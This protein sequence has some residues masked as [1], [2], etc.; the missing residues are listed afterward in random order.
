MRIKIKLTVI[1]TLAVFALCLVVPKGTT[2]TQVV[3][4]GQRFK[5]IKVVNDMPADQLGRVMNMFSAS[6][7]VNCNFCHI[8]N[9]KD[10]DKDDKK[11]KTTAREMIKMTLEINKGHFDSRTEVSCNTCHGGHERPMSAPNLNRV[12]AAE[13]PKQP[14]IK[15]TVDQI[16]DKYTTALGGKDK[17]AKVTSRY[18]KASRIEADGKTTEIEEV[19]QKG[20][21]LMVATQYKD[22]LISEAYDGTAVWKHGT[23]GD[24]ALRS[25]ESEQIKRNAQVFANPDIKTIYAKLDF[26]FVDRI[27]DRDVYLV[28]AT[29]AD[30]QRERLY[31]D[32]QTGLLVRRTSST[33]TIFGPFVYQ[34]DYGDYKDFGGVK[35]PATVRFAVPNISWT[36]KLIEVKNNAEVPDAKF[37]HP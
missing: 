18:I 21:K 1:F 29:T 37:V 23:G 17:L 6:L 20:G 13:R 31:F 19:W 24:I 26:R 3:T 34:V 30:N 16:L 4:A 22:H 2:Q 33:Q 25:D 5:N 28:T 12:V 36:K 7:G 27:S 32:V 9:D 11:E 14:D 35:L 8:S 10:F 15:P